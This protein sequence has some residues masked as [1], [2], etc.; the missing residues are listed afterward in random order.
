VLALIIGAIL[1]V[2]VFAMSGFARAAS[3]EDLIDDAQPSVSKTGIV[4]FR[5]DLEEVKGAVTEFR[6]GVLPAFADARGLSDAEFQQEARADFPRLSDVLLDRQGEIL[7]AIE[8]GVSN[9]EAHQGDYEAADDIPAPGVPVTVM[10]WFVLV[11][12]LGLVGLGVWALRR[13]G[14]TAPVVAIGAVGLLLV[15]FTLA[16]GMPDK[17]RRAERLIDSLDISEAVATSTRAQ[18]DAAFAAAGETTKFFQ[19]FAD[20]RGETQDEFVASLRT[21]FPKVARVVDDPDVFER[22]EGEVKYRED[23]VD[24]FADV[25]DVPMQTTAW[26]FVALGAVLVLGTGAALLASRLR[27]PGGAPD[28]GTADRARSDVPD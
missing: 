7:G 27:A 17:T 15:T 9:L 2:G 20:A 16:T 23:H 4:R 24:E 10:P 26:V 13:P 19:D 3:G 25:K 14:S 21:D 6:D 8:K 18:F 11:I 12:G 5:A 22:I 1:V 28:A